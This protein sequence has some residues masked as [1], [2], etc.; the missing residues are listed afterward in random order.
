M[1]LPLTMIDCERYQCV[2]LNVSSIGAAHPTANLVSSKRPNLLF[3]RKT[4]GP[5]EF[6]FSQN[7]LIVWGQTSSCSNI[8]NPPDYKTVS[9]P[10]N[11]DFGLWCT[12]NPADCCEENADTWDAFV[13][14]KSSLLT[15]MTFKGY[16][17]SV[18]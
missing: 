2:P 9:L 5:I 16:L 3:Y 18:K 4:S 10:E 7:G 13:M 8:N 15:A 17:L 1:E 11:L 6:V 12:F 14:I